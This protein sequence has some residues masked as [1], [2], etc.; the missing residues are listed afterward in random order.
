MTRNDD[1][2]EE[3]DWRDQISFSK[4]YD[5]YRQQ[6]EETMSKLAALLDGH[7]GQ[8]FVAKHLIELP[9]ITSPVQPPPYRAGTRQRPLELEN[10]NKMVEDHV[11]EPTVLERQSPIVFA[12]NEDGCLQFCVIYKQLNAAVLRDHYPIT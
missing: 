11:A 7:S 5:E 3:A 1:E 8:M 10:V 6:C 12:T 2:K 4:M 9:K